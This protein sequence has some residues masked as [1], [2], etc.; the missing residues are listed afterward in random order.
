MT[1]GL[2]S[3]LK[4]FKTFLVLGHFFDMKQFNSHKLWCPPKCV[5][6]TLFNITMY[7]SR[8]FIV[9]ASS[10]AVTKLPNKIL[11]FHDFQGPVIQFHDFQGLEN[12]ILKF[13]VFP[14]FS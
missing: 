12:K 9:L 13:H 1:L 10:S 6:L 2:L 5:P 3:L 14:G 7:S 4:F 11:I 8:S